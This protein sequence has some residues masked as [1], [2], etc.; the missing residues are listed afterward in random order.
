MQ[1]HTQKSHNIIIDKYIYIALT[2]LS[3]YLVYKN[4]Y[5]NKTE[6]VGGIQNQI[7]Y[8]YTAVRVQSTVSR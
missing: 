3:H 8:L 5:K 2:S 4:N 7:C 1:A 6:K